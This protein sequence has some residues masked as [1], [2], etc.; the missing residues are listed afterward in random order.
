[1]MDEEILLNGL[2]QSNLKYYEAL[3][4]AYSSYVVRVII[5]VGGH[6]LSKEEIEEVSAD[7]FIKCWEKREGLSIETGKLKAY[8]GVMARNHTLNRL[9]AQGKAEIIPIEEDTV[10]FITP[11][12]T[13][14]EKEGEKLIQE[15]LNVLPEPDR[16]IFIRRYFYMEKVLDIGKVLGINS[17]TVATKLF[18]GKKKLEAVLKKKG[19]NYE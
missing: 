2:K 17:Q 3:I 18:R 12:H 10:D 7:V 15:L 4:D 1:M 9:R 19:V 11:E 5:K 14:M 6:S 16:E 8:L 13:L